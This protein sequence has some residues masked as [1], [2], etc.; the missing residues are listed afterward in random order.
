MICLFDFSF[1]W[2]SCCFAVHSEEVNL[3]VIGSYNHASCSLCFLVTEYQALITMIVKS[4]SGGV[5][6]TGGN[7]TAE[8]SDCAKKKSRGDHKCE[9]QSLETSSTTVAGSGCKPILRSGKGMNFG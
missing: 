2:F 7:L 8:G 9:K 3:L 1:K 6:R 5:K 4:K